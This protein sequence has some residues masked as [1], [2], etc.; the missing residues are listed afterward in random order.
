MKY[1]I[2]SPYFQSVYFLPSWSFKDIIPATLFPLLSFLYWIKPYAYKYI[3]LFFILK[4]FQLQSSLQQR[5]HWQQCFLR[6]CLSQYSTDTIRLWLWDVRFAALL[7]VLKQCL[8][9][10]ASNYLLNRILSV[11]YSSHIP[12]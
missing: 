5:F 4:T 7:T 1:L 9:R 12:F 8:A 6:V 10:V 2:L 11:S 3:A